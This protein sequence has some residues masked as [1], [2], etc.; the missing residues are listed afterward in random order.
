MFDELS[1]FLSLWHANCSVFLICSFWKF[2]HVLIKC[3]PLKIICIEEDID[4]LLN[5][6]LLRF[7]HI[8]HNMT[9]MPK[10]IYLLVA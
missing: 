7:N 6:I 5:K 10:E 1:K 8:A 4:T 2:T 9:P 3:V